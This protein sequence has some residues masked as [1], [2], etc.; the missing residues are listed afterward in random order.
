MYQ[1]SRLGHLILYYRIAQA[2]I[3][4]AQECCETQKLMPTDGQPA[5]NVD[6]ARDEER[7]GKGVSATVERWLQ[8]RT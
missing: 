7:L 4:R 1:R 5:E 3:C 8:G 6:S 2:S